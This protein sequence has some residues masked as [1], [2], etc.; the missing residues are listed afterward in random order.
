MS[1]KNY[2]PLTKHFSSKKKSLLQLVFF[3]IILNSCKS[4]NDNPNNLPGINFGISTYY[5]SF[6]FSDSG[7]DTLSKT[8]RINFNDWAQQN[9]GFVDLYFVDNENRIIGTPDSPVSLSINNEKVQNGIIQLSSFQKPND[10]LEIK[11]HFE[12]SKNS[13]N[14]AGYLM[15]QDGKIERINS[16]EIQ[17]TSG[18]ELFKWNARQEVVMNPLKKGLLWFLIVVAGALLIWFLLIRNKMYPKMA[19]GHIILNSPYYK[20]LKTKGARQIVFTNK[21]YKQGWFSKLFAGEIIYEKNDFWQDEIIFSPARRRQLR[22]KMPGHYS[23]DPFTS[24]IDQGQ[25]YTI[26]GNKEVVKLSF[27]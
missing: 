27:L 25:T 4:E 17:N 2:F 24:K 14:F 8:L 6:L 15:L 9:K 5:D 22:I 20:S 26:K 7:N 19:R 10:S 1:T 16:I 18:V 21:P 3:I 13:K 11:L 12:P 23:I